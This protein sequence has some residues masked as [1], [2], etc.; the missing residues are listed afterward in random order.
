MLETHDMQGMLLSGY[1]KQPS[2]MYLFYSIRAAPTAKAWFAAIAP[3]VTAGGN[4]DRNRD[5]S[6]NVALTYKGFAKLGFSDA[7]LATF[8][9]PFAEDMSEFNWARLLGDNPDSWQWGKQDHRI[10]VLLMLF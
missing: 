2:A 8:A 6:L 5:V 10:H 1:G 7:T 9:R 4:F 3:H